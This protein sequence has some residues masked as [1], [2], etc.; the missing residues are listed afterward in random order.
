M[1]AWIEIIV[2]VDTALSLYVAPYMGAWIEMHGLIQSV[3]VTLVAP[4]MGA[5]IEISVSSSNLITGT[6]PPTWG[7]GLKYMPP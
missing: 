3:K 4:Y 5:W 2:P 7:R 1:G 6:S